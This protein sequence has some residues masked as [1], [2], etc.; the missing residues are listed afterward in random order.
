[1]EGSDFGGDFGI[2]PF[3][4]YIWSMD[5]KIRLVD[6]GSVRVGTWDFSLPSDSNVMCHKFLDKEYQKLFKVPKWSLAIAS[7]GDRFFLFEHNIVGVSDR[8]WVSSQERWYV[9]P[10]R[11]DWV[12]EAITS[13]QIDYWRIK[14]ESASEF[15]FFHRFDRYDGFS[16]CHRYDCPKDNE[17][18]SYPK[19]LR[20]SSL[21]DGGSIVNWLSIKDYPKTVIVSKSVVRDLIISSIF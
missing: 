8:R 1:M 5:L 11:S 2:I 21:G 13:G 6:D 16:E 19:S 10:L 15:G 18:L 9:F 4:R 20:P 17:F 14:F 7:H 12:S 3:F